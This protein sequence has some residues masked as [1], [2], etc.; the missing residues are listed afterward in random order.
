MADSTTPTTK[1][2]Q[3]LREKFVANAI[4]T[5]QDFT[6]L[7]N[8]NLN[9]ADD[10]KML[11]LT[12]PSLSVVRQPG[13]DTVLRFYGEPSGKTSAWQMRLIGTDKP[14]LGFSNQPNTTALFLDGTTGN[15]GIGK[16]NP[17]ARLHVAGGLRVDA[18]L[19]VLGGLSTGTGNVG[20]GANSPAQKL[21]VEGQLNV[22]KDLANNLSNA[23]QLA[24]KGPSV[25][26][27]FIDADPGHPDWA[28]HVNEGKLS[29][30]RSPDYKDLVLDSSGNV[31]IGTATP[32]QRLT[33]EGL[34]GMNVAKD[35][36]NNL[37][38]AGQLAI[39]GAHAQLDFIDSDPNQT[40]WAIHVN[41]GKL[42]FVRSPDI[43]DLVID[44]KGNVG[45][46]TDTPTAKLHVAGSMAVSSFI[47]ASIY[48]TSVLGYEFESDGI[49]MTP[50]QDMNYEKRIFGYTGENQTFKIE[51]GIAYV[52]VKLWGAGGGSGFGCG[53]WRHG[54]VGGGGGHT[55][56][57]FPVAPG[58]TFI[59]VVG[60]GGTASN[61]TT[62]SYGGGG[63][64]GNDNNKDKTYSGHGGGYCGIFRNDVSQH[65]ALAIAGGGGG[66]GPSR[67]G[68]GNVG[69]AGGGH[70][71]EPGQS[72]YKNNLTTDQY[73][74]GG[75]GGTQW[76]GGTA[77]TYVE[78]SNGNR[79]GATA[80]GSLQGGRGATD[81]YGGGGGG[82]YFGGG[83]GSYS[84]N[85]TMGGGGGGS[86]FIL[87]NFPL[88][89][90][91]AGL[92]KEPAFS[93]DP[94]IKSSLPAGHT[95][96]RGATPPTSIGFGYGGE[97]TTGTNPSPGSQ[98]GGHALAVIYLLKKIT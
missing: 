96:P 60:R 70:A 82:G 11:R 22:G 71:G 68:T 24:I 97:I 49:I 37:S 83:G 36:A 2:R 43:K 86:G 79:G 34:W 6:D 9:L 28:I 77:S 3:Q 76:G 30:V 73:R 66:G 39:K 23:G 62:Q 20:I 4:P 18:D 40:D 12:D 17:S 92:R 94:D 81:C 58:D 13:D 35:P 64:N 7:I 33:V 67:G 42:S 8:A 91:F 5:Q 56:G 75:G 27:D 48:R 41:E 44:D 38:N 26:L 47:R 57:L 29:F 10:G 93:G 74:L 84:E 32:A 31:G 69:G 88:S 89:G 63:T 1:T 15:V 46:G 90:T 80:G 95:Y 61:G 72:P 55:R 98:S 45:I 85:N 50:C 16:I 65:N 54:A 53:D 21:M 25:Q 78:L 52:F 51:E 14:G 19:T 59:V 87:S